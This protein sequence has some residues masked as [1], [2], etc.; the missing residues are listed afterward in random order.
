MA[1]V[2]CFVA[3]RARHGIGDDSEMHFFSA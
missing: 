1:D 2:C 3:L